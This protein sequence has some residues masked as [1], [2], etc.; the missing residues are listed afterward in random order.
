MFPT[1]QTKLVRFDELERQLQDPEILADT[2]K[3]LSCQREHGGLAKIARTIREF[4]QLEVDIAAV[5]QMIDSADDAETRE[6]A[7]AELADLQ[8]RYD[9]IRVELEDMVTAGDSL[10]RGSLIME[11]RAGTGG[12][13]ASLFARDGNSGPCSYE[14]RHCRGNGRS[15]GY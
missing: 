3:M 8:A 2:A 6:Y 12:D 4:N 1:L 5:R 13:E 14:C 9:T 7:Q 15:D 11:I 10:T